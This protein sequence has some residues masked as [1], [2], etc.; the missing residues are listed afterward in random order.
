MLVLVIILKLFI[1]STPIKKPATNP[2][3]IAENEAVSEDGKN[4]FTF[5]NEALPLN[6]ARVD[7]KI[8]Y[9][10]WKHS[11]R[12]VHS[13]ILHKKA[14]KLFP[15]IVPILR[16]YGIPE[17]FKYIPLVE[18]GLAEGVSPKGAAGLWQ[19]MP[20]TARNYG[21]KVGH[22]KDERYN[23]RKST[24]AACK[25]LKE[26]YSEMDSWTLAAAAYN[27]GS[28]RLQKAINKK[29]KGN[30]YLMHLNRETGN[31]VYNLIAMKEVISNP[32]EYGYKPTYTVYNQIKTGELL[33][34]N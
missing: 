20:Q 18:S 3:Q 16:L 31:Y 9:S 34:L 26:L 12:R 23:V 17:D 32:E 33:T 19:F 30:Y 6:N 21:L 28:P 22:G 2:R 10:L 25:Y 24:I 4:E 14:E 15:I 7:K 29:N 1:Y 27:A 5:A 8:K 11:Y 13:S